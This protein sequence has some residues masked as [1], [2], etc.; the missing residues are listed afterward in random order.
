[1]PSRTGAGARDRPRRTRRPG[2]VPRPAPR[3][4]PLRGRG[5]VGRARTAGAGFADPRAEGPLIAFLLV[6]VTAPVLRRRTAA[7]IPPP[8]G[9]RPGETRDHGARTGPG[10]PRADQAADRRAA[11]RLATRSSS[12]SS[13]TP[14]RSATRRCRS[15][16][17]RWRRRDTSG[18]RKGHVGKRPKTWYSLTREGPGG[19][20]VARGGAAGD[21]RRAPATAC[22]P[23]R[24]AL[25]PSVRPSASFRALPG[26]RPGRTARRRPSP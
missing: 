25:R 10:D 17:P 4:R 15:R 26:R 23:A 8:G 21:R 6:A 1:M 3:G 5:G 7:H 24:P 2:A 16:P 12:P 20:R 14:W 19:V 9:G 18:I 13:A 11:R 22:C